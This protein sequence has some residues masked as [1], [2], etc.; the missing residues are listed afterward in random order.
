MIK[1]QKKII[2]T[3]ILHLGDQSDFRVK[4]DKNMSSL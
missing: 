2:L 4:H 3:K 1:F